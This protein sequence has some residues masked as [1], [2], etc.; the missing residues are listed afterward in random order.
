[1]RFTMTTHTCDVSL[2]KSNAMELGRLL[3]ELQT[4]TIRSG[5]QGVRT[6]EL[7]ELKDSLNNFLFTCRIQD[8][9]DNEIRTEYRNAWNADVL[10]GGTEMSK[11]LIKMK[12]KL[13]HSL[14]ECDKV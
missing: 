8:K 3:A 10:A 14:S 1:M 6:E 4:K 7:N 13:Y 12:D 2:C 11:A 9:D 5:I